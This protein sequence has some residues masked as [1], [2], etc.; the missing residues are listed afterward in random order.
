MNSQPYRPILL[1]SFLLLFSTSSLAR[2]VEDSSSVAVPDTITRGKVSKIIL[3]AVFY[4]P[5]TRIGGGGAAGL[6]WTSTPDGPTSSVLA[7]LIYTQRSQITASVAPDLYLAGDRYRLSGAMAYF[8]FPDHF[9]GVGQDTPESAKEEFSARTFETMLRFQ[10]KLAP[11]LRLGPMY[12]LRY[13]DFYKVEEGRSIDS[14]MLVGTDGGLSSGAGFSLEWDR[15]DSQFY[16]TRGTYAILEGALFDGMLGSDYDFTRLSADVRVFR[17][18]RRRHVLAFQGVA[19]V[20]GGTVP[21]H[22]LPGVGGQNMLRGYYDGRYRDN[23]M[24]MVQAEYRFPVWKRLGAVVFA[25]AGNVSSRFDNF[26]L[27]DL[28]YGGGAGLRY[29]VS[30]EGVNIRLDYAVTPISSGMYITIQEAF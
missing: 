5:E 20:S 10:W 1:L 4:T 19:A 17:P 28:K 13:R 24:A 14:G 25:G 22:L 21:F 16:P 29:R 23:L 6:Y 9:Y 2:Q 27:D 8:D 7:A 15:R 3:P 12:Y 18:V 30:P 11:G 26:A